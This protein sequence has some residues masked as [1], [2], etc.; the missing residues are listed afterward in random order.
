MNR[1]LIT[2]NI[3][4]RWINT[5]AMTL[6][7][8][9][10]IAP[11]VSHAAGLVICGSES[12]AE[13]S[14]AQAVNSSGGSASS[15]T[16]FNKDSCQFNQ[17]IPEIT[18]II[19]YLIGTA[20][21]IAVAWIISIAVRMVLFAGDGKAIEGLKHDLTSVIIGLIMIML[22]FVFVNTIYNIFQIKINGATEFNFNPFNQ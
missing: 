10:G 12:G 22:A 1:F 20:G 6:V 11:M 8:V 17:L 16:Q 4:L 9:S 5:I 19:N 13:Y 21:L 2:R 14:D 3:F 18:H 15:L 7:L